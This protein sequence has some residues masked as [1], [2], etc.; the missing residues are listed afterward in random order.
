MFL[1]QFNHHVWYCLD[2]PQPKVV[3]SATKQQAKGMFI[4]YLM[5]TGEKA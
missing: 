5:Q 2:L 1:I 3:F 4:N